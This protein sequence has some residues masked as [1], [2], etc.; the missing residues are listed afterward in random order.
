[1]Q[2]IK[3]QN[4]ITIAGIVVMIIIMLILIG[5]SFRIGLSSFNSAVDSRYATELQIVMQAVLH[6]YGVAL[7]TQTIV[8]D[9]STP[10]NFVGTRIER[11]E[12]PELKDNSWTLSPAQAVGYKSYFALYPEDLRKLK[13]RIDKDSGVEDDNSSNET[14]TE[15]EV[16]V[17]LYYVNYYSGEIYDNWHKM[18]S[19]GK[20]LYLKLN[21]ADPKTKEPGD[22]TSFVD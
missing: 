22:N 2:K 14:N 19:E 6:E 18:D 4:G 16:K 13:I 20:E 21:S 10:D 11:D 1:M 7:Q 12:L 5:I 9:G 3:D 8:D 17:P 15:D